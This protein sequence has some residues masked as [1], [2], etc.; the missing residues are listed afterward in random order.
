MTYRELD[1]MVLNRDVPER[2]LRRGDVGA[3]VHVH[4]TDVFEVE[5]VRASGRTHAV[6]TLT[7][8]DIRAIEDRDLVA[9]RSI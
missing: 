7:S 6:V 9:V 8:A 5:F 4:A 2:G 3:V 1:S